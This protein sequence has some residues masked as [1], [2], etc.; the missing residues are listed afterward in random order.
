[1]HPK[2]YHKYS[3][4]IL[5]GSDSGGGEAVPLD[6]DNVGGVFLVLV[7]GS[8]FAGLISLGELMFEVYIKEDRVSVRK[9]CKTKLV[10]AI[11]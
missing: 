7:F 10:F 4:F 8:A 6:L 9:P 2:V 1:M 3:T 5:Q 11:P